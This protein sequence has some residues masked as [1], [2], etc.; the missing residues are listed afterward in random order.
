[1]E[2]LQASDRQ[3]AT[4]CWAM[5][6]HANHASKYGRF[7]GPPDVKEGQEPIRPIGIPIHA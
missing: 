3:S 4:V 1:M 6:G 7:E 5:A 2:L